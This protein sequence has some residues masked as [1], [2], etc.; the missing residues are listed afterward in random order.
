MKLTAALL[1]ALVGCAAARELMAPSP[2][3]K[4]NAQKAEQ[5]RAAAAKAKQAAQQAAKRLKPPCF[6]PVR[7]RVLGPGCRQGSCWGTAGARRAATGCSWAASSVLLLS[8][9]PLTLL[10]PAPPPPPTPPDLLLPHPLLRHLN[11]RCRVWPRLQCLPLVRHL[12]RQ[13]ARQHRLPS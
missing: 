7:Q 13:A 8:H 4:L 11:R 12:L 5:D 10:L 6:V 3:E 9:H 1:L 2:T